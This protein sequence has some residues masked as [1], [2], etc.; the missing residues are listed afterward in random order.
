[1]AQ[2]PET[3]D[4]KEINFWPYAILGMI[5]TVVMLG[6]WTIK[7]AV[8]NP[9]QESDVYMMKYQDVDANINE[10]LA[11]QEA[12]FSKYRIDLNG[13]KLQMG[14]NRV[15]VLIVRKNDDSAVESAEIIAKVTRPTTNREDIE[16]KNFRFEGG[17]YVSEP[18][19]LKKPGRW[20]IQVKVA[21]GSDVAYETYKTY[22]PLPSGE[23]Q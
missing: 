1:M 20:N 14:E 18:F 17:R 2:T 8:S 3:P 10:I 15:R 23:A 5:L 16:L 21:I 13:N 22:I 12:F 19:E 7:V 4:K 6:V 9:V 11:K